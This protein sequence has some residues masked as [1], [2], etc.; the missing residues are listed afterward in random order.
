[1]SPLDSLSSQAPRSARTRGLLWCS[2]VQFTMLIVAMGCAGGQDPRSPEA[3]P[4]ADAPAWITRGCRV[5]WQDQTSQSQVLCGVG[6]AGP[7]R[8]PLAARETAIARARSGIARSIEVTI[9]S[10]VRIETSSEDANDGALR[11]IVHQLTS[12]SIP[13]CR[14]ESVWQAENGQI[15]A[16]LSLRVEKVQQSLRKNRSLSPMAR[17]DLA[18]RAAVAFG[19]MNA[20][21]DAERDEERPSQKASE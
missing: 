8:N 18:Q 4:L 17:E 21:F 19:A 5:Y 2:L 13:A 10:L 11:A 3:D 15:F 12:T 14:V 9:E 16:L 7:N 1:M 20:A 6:S